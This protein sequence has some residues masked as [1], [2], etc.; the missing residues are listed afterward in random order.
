MAQAIFELVTSRTH[1][2][3][4]NHCIP[5]IASP[6]WN[7]QDQNTARE[8]VCDVLYLV[9]TS[10]NIMTFISP[11]FCKDYYKMRAKFHMEILLGDFNAEIH[12]ENILTN[13]WE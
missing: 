6:V 7:K 9:L 2:G 12:W 3:I 4:A 8:Y 1:I 5:T 11:K 10:H 13:S